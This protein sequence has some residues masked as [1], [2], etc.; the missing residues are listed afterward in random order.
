MDIIKIILFSIFG[1]VTTL[2]I[3]QF[4]PE[5]APFVQLSCIIIIFTLAYDGLKEMLTAVTDMISGYG[6]VQGE[7][8]FLLIKVL[9]IAVISKIGT[10]V[11]NDSGSSVLATGVE[12]AGKIAILT[13]CFP[14]LI[15]ML[16]LTT[17]IIS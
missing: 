15:N 17:G 13:L 14:L 8:I 10:D 1:A 6:V 5:F 4:K 9:T 7:Y 16:N 11:C 12:I 2:I 3:K